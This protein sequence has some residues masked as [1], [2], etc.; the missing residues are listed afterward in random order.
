LLETIE[1]W[2]QLASSN[3]QTTTFDWEIL[4]TTSR[5]NSPRIYQAPNRSGQNE[6]GAI[7]AFNA[8]GNIS[9]DSPVVICIS[10]AH[11]APKLGESEYSQEV[12]GLLSS[13]GP[14]RRKEL[15]FQLTRSEFRELL[16]HENVTFFIENGLL[17]HD[18]GWAEMLRDIEFKH[19]ETETKPHKS[20][21]DVLNLRS[22]IAAKKMDTI[23]PSRLQTYFD[24]PRQY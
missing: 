20:R 23:S 15:D 22:P 7:F 6:G 2:L 11:S 5:L 8:F 3:I 10:S 19:T 17:E 14:R 1:E 4:R 21:V 24:C 12:A 9:F 18:L 13:L 16:K